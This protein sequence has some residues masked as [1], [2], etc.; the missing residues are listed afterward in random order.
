LELIGVAESIGG[1]GRDV[2][3]HLKQIANKAIE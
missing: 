2:P 3:L 1:W